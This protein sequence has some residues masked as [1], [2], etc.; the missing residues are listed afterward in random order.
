MAAHPE[1]QGSPGGPGRAA[2]PTRPCC[3]ILT[4]AAPLAAAESTG[5]A[6]LPPAPE[7]PCGRTTCELA[8]GPGGALDF[9]LGSVPVPELISALRRKVTPTDLA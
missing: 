6:P 1:G 3:V 5:L 9:G 7:L 2:C 4:P 8:A